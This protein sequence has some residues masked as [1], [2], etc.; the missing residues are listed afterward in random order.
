MV[1]VYSFAFGHSL[2][3]SLNDNYDIQGVSG[4]TVIKESLKHWGGEGG[5]GLQ[6]QSP[7]GSATY[8]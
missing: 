4:V 3:L 6:P 2:S 7:M 8:V 1:C 5:E